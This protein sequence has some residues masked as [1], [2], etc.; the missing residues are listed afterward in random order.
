VLFKRAEQGLLFVDAGAM[1]SMFSKRSQFL[2]SSEDTSA[3]LTNCIPDSIEWSILERSNGR[4]GASVNF[5]GSVASE[6]D[7]TC[8]KSRTPP[9]DGHPS[10]KRPSEFE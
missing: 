1:R 8:G 4:Q 10:C 6:R 3:E 9:R 5:A 2:L 7:T